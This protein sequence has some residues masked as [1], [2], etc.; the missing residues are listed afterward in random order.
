MYF[1]DS[2]Q[3]LTLTS[4]STEVSASNSHNTIASLITWHFQVVHTRTCYTYHGPY[5]LTQ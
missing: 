4:N 3:R 1:V 2:H 5:G